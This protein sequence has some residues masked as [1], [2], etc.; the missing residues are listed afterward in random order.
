MTVSGP[1]AIDTSKIWL[2]HEHILVDFVAADS[3]D[4][5]LWNQD[6]VIKQMEPYLQELSNYHV[7]YFVDATPNFLGRDVE[8][9]QMLSHETGLQ[10]ITNTGLYGAIG[11]R[12]IPDFAKSQTAEEMAAKWIDEFKYGIDGTN[13]KP[14]F[15]KISVDD[16]ESLDAIDAKLVKAAA[17]TNLETGLTIASHTGRAKVMWPQ[18]EILE[19]MGVSPKSFIWVHA[20]EEKDF[21]QFIKAAR[22]GCWISIDGFGWE[23]KQQIEILLFAKENDFLN[24]VLISHDAG[25]YDPQKEEQ[26]IQPYTA[27]FEV[28]LPRLET[29][30]FSKEEINTLI[31][32]NPA[33]ALSI[34]LTD[35][36]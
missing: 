10:I 31:K 7:D 36:Y 26:S 15:I 35:E 28:V 32:Y 6:S 1:V 29:L 33:R 27:I 8:L 14:G 16:Q 11:D 20:Q 22:A 17:L 30:G 3:Y 25:W 2:A 13:I 24:S 19:S 5:S 4:P 12:H 18:L 23:I 34:S 9:L 21:N